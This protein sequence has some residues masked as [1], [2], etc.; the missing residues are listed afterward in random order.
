MCYDFFIQNYTSPMTIILPKFDLISGLVLITRQKRTS[1]KTK[2]ITERQPN[3][4]Q[5]I[6]V[7]NIDYFLIKKMKKKRRIY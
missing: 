6:L 4:L 5:I 2:N 3:L 7:Y 1:K